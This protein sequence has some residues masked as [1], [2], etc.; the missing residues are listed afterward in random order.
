MW[1]IVDWMLTRSETGFWPKTIFTS[2]FLCDLWCARFYITVK[3]GCCSTWIYSRSLSAIGHISIL[4]RWKRSA[5]IC[6]RW[7]EE[8]FDCLLWSAIFNRHAGKSCIFV[9]FFRIIS[10]NEITTE[11]TVINSTISMNHTRVKAKIQLIQAFL[12][13]NTAVIEQC[14]HVSQIRLPSQW[15]VSTNKCY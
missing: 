8:H 10:C 15:F 12:C 14:E 4:R 9:K 1:A 2:C 3:D 11:R 13:K 6:L 5:I 7:N